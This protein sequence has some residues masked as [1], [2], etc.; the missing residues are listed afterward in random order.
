MGKIYDGY[1]KFCARARAMTYMHVLSPAY[2]RRIESELGVTPAKMLVTHFGTPD[3]YESWAKLESPYGEDYVLSIGR[4]NRD[5]DYLCE[6]WR[7]PCLQGHRLVIIADLWRP[8]KP[9]PENVTHLTDVIGDQSF[10]YIAN[11]AMSVVPIDDPMICSGDTVLLNSMMMKVPVAV[12]APSTLS[13][14]YIADGH[15]GIYLKRDAESD[16][17]LIAEVLDS[18][19]RLK[20]LGER[21]RQTYIERFSRKAMGQAIARELLARG[22]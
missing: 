20:E 8:A 19:S 18:P 1:M 15:D 4:S 10:P 6:V 2:A 17:R 14:M 3:R 5:F 13:E 22:L 12:S 11:A 16:A 9:L 21:A 7:R